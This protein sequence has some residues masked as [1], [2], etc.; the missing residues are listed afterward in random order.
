VARVLGDMA[1][2]EAASVEAFERLAA[3]L[4][5]HGAPPRLTQAALAAAKDETRHARVMTALAERAGAVVD[6]PRCR[7]R[8]KRSLEAIAI[9]NAVEGCVRETF[10]AAVAAV[11]AATA[12][13]EG[14]RRAMRRIAPDEMRHADLSW[15]VAGWLEG[16]LDKGSRARV[17]GARRRAAV[18]LLRETRDGVAP[19]IVSELGLPDAA[20]AH[21][22]AHDLAAALWAL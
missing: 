18:A 12:S 22:I 19:E 21:G 2:L 11:Q 3:E 9:E 7:R 6:A 13:H 20:R 8:R 5:A 15:S 10:G 16:R 17:A 14:V 1:F 4:A